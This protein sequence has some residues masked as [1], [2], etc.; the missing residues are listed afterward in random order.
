MPKVVVPSV[1]KNTAAKAKKAIEKVGLVYKEGDSV[2]SNEIKKGYV[3]SQSP[4]NSTS[5]DKGSTITVILS[6]GPEPVV[7]TVYTT[8]TFT[9]TKE[10]VGIPDT[11]DPLEQHHLRAEVI[12][13]G[14]TIV[15]VNEDILV[16][17]FPRICEAVTSK[18]G[19][20]G[21]LKIS[22]DGKPVGGT[23]D[24]TFTKQQ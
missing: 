4:S 7:E 13:D 23:S 6:K 3:V 21:V 1:V 5:V 22:L 9:F 11:A 17:E 15:I 8:G 20:K 16:G 19:N 24:V 2:Y 18:S 10:A 12:Q 14:N